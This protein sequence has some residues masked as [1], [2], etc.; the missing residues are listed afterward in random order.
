MILASGKQYSN[1]LLVFYK[2]QSDMR[3]LIII[4]L[5]TLLPCCLHAQEVHENAQ[6]HFPEA[7]PAGN[8]SGITWL[9]GDRYAVVSDKAQDDGFFVFQIDIDSVTGDI[10]SA[11]NLGFRSS[12]QPNR[13]DEGI[14]WC[15]QTKTLWVSGERDDR[16]LEYDTTGLR[17]GR[18]LP[19]TEALSHLPANLGLE[20]LTYNRVTQTFWT[21]NEA[22]HITLQ[23]YGA[24][25]KPA[26]SLAY[27]LDAPEGDATKA[28]QYAH[29]LPALCALDDGSLL[30]LERE[31]YVPKSKIGAWVNCKLF[32]VAPPAET[33]QPANASPDTP[34]KK[35][36][37][38]QWRTSLSLFGRSLANYEG[39]CLGPTL[40]D[41]SR[42]LILVADSQNQYAGV[43][44][45]WMK[46]IKLHAATGEEI[47]K[48][49]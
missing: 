5:T 6:H 36:L 46:S 17:T 14:A 9:G 33:Q 41:G 39:M 15:P 40:A 38:A 32:L 48:K 12:G 26:T 23:A 7:I 43:L 21:C 25:L 4:F 49:R 16:I 3:K 35:Q 20:A 11:R 18:A 2:K 30:T 8:Y 37:L 42:V 27:A 28:W 1:Q 44:K 19:T 13:D 34:V 24:D 45:D 10:R 31:F 47:N 29:G 22:G